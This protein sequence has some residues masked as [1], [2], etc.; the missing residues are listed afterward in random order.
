MTQ[1]QIPG[2]KISTSLQTLAA[3]T[4]PKNRS[5]LL[6]ENSND[7]GSWVLNFEKPQ[8]GDIRVPARHAT[9]VAGKEGRILTAAF[10]AQRPGTNI[11]RNAGLN[12]S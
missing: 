9:R 7:F 1:T 2:L 6:P 11:D 12:F 4:G 8:M 5:W 3:K 10:D